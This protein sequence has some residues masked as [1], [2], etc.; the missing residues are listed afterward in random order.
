M[1]VHRITRWRASLAI[2]MVAALALTA[3]AAFGSQKTTKATT[4]PALI[5]S[6]RPA[7][8]HGLFSVPAG[9]TRLPPG[10]WSEVERPSSPE[11]GSTRP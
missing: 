1:N 4:L 8:P 5:G 6:S 2:V 7:T 9:R 11:K 3:G 10:T